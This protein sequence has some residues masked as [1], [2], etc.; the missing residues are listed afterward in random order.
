MTLTS[1]GTIVAEVTASAC[2]TADAT[3]E[4]PPP[5]GYRTIQLFR[6]GGAPADLTPPPPV[7]GMP[8][9]PSETT[10]S[11]VQTLVEYRKQVAPGSTSPGGR[12]EVMLTPA[13][14][15]S[16]EITATT[17]LQP[18]HLRRA[19]APGLV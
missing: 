19:Y 4:T 5:R 7:R 1:R 11:G 13:L 14:D 17:E 16:S 8:Q 3:V 12:G 18:P 10:E 9:S 15:A 6:T 2:H